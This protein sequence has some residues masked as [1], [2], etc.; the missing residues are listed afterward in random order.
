MAQKIYD[1]YVN[2]NLLSALFAFL[3]MTQG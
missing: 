1:V 2:V 3:T